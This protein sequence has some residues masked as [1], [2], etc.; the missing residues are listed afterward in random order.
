MPSTPGSK[1]EAGLEDGLLSA[2]PEQLPANLMLLH[3]LLGTHTSGNN[4]LQLM[5]KHTSDMHNNSGQLWWSLRQ[6]VQSQLHSN[7]LSCGR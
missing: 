7:L 3:H 6:A 2:S 5:V 4:C 1:P